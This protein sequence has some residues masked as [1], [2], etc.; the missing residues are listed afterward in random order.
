MFRNW[1]WHHGLIAGI[2]VA[3]LFWAIVARL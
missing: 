3:S 1:K 2:V